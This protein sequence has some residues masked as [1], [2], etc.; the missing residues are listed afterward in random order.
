MFA[1]MDVLQP[2]GSF[3]DRGMGNLIGRLVHEGKKN[4]ICSSGGNAGHAA[5]YV[6]SRLGV[7]ISVI[8]PKTT[9]KLMID[10]IKEQ[11]AKVEVCGDN[12]NQADARAQALLAA[13]PT[14][15][16]IHPFDHSWLWEGH[17]SVVAE[18]ALDM[19]AEGRAPPAAIICSVGGGGLLNGVC[20]GLR[21]LG[22]EWADVE[23]IAT[24]T[25]G[26]DSFAQALAKGE[27]VRLAGITSL[28]SSLGAVAVAP[29][30]LQHTERAVRSI[31][32]TDAEAVDAVGRTLED[33]RVLVEP[34]CG[35][36][37]AALYGRRI[38][39]TPKMQQRGV[40]VIVCGGGG[41]NTAVLQKYQAQCGLAPSKL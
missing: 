38:E 14:A 37:L 27:V 4:F 17:A 24:E 20:Q 30:T 2:T 22:P 10:K 23:V 19:Q 40:V 3:K 5:A 9:T 33:H 6:C 12:W 13:D 35:A 29:S 8:V 15:A 32:V 36:A 11:G 26:A 31:V 28:A 41:I 39:P 34:A 25:K 1:K 16:Y 18:I 21:K 7:P